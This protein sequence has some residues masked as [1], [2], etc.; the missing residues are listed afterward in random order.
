MPVPRLD[1][2]T[3]HLESYMTYLETG[4]SYFNENF[5]HQRDLKE[6]WFQRELCQVVLSLG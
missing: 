1:L 3:F 5:T 2:T 4:W 6:K